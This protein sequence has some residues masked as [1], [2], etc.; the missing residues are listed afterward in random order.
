I[1]TAGSHF[2]LMAY[3]GEGTTI[4]DV[5]DINNISSWKN[6]FTTFHNANIQTI[7]QSV[8]RWYNVKV[9]YQ[10]NLTDKRYNINMPRNAKF[11]DLLRRLE[12]QGARFK[13]EGRTIIVL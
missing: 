9:V 10:G 1:K 11:Y 6:G 4:T 8:G 2:D 13:I 7:M 3:P 5:I 12:M